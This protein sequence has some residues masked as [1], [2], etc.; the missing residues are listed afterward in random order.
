MGFNEIF[1]LD[2]RKQIH[3][4]HERNQTL[5]RKDQSCYPEIE[6]LDNDALRAKTEELKKYIHESANC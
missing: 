2:F 4:R 1:K 5:G 3:T 6:A